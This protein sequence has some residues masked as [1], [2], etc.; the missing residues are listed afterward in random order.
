MRIAKSTRNPYFAFTSNTPTNLEIEWSKPNGSGI[1]IRNKT[2]VSITKSPTTKAQVYI[3]D[4]RI[5]EK[6]QFGLLS[7]IPFYFSDT[8]TCFILRINGNKVCL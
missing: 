2:T 3:G 1:N 6:G 4:S 5:Y 7:G 8:M